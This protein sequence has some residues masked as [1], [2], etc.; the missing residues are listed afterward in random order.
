[1]HLSMFGAGEVKVCTKYS[2]YA[3][4]RDTYYSMNAMQRQLKIDT[5]NAAAVFAEEESNPS[6]QSCRNEAIHCSSQTVCLL[7]VKP[8]ENKIVLPPFSIVEK[9]F[10]DAS[11]LVNSGNCIVQDPGSQKKHYICSC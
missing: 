2:R 5:F 7:S 10:E 1:M 9:I 4:T 3:V 11:A 6:P 8:E